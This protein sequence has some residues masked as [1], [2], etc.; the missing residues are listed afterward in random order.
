VGR[1]ALQV[2][3]A[4][5]GRF[6]VDLL[7]AHNRA[8][9][10]VEQARAFRP[11]AVV[12][13]N[14]AHYTAVR[15]ALAPLGIAVHA[16]DAAGLL[17]ER[18]PDLLLAAMVGFA[19]LAPTLAAAEAGIPL[20]LANKE[21]LVVAGE[22]I[23][24]A[25]ARHGLPVLPVDSEHSAIFQCLQGEDAHAVEKIIL[26]ASGGPFRGL[27]KASLEKV[28][29][30]EALKHPNWSMGP[31]ITVDSATLM[32][33]AL[34]MIEARWL[35]GL[36]PAQIEVV[37]H[38][39]SVIHSMVQFVDGSVKAQMG[40]PD[41]KLPIQYALAYPERWPSDFGGFSID[42]Y[43]ALTFEQPDAGAFPALTLAR[44]AMERGGNGPCVLNAANEAAVGAFLQGRIAFPRIA[45]TAAR[46]L[47]T[48]P[49]IEKP[50]LADYAETHEA[51]LA[52]AA[53]LWS[54]QK[55]DKFAKG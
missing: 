48:M 29:A 13:G 8:A 39:Q 14:G 7:T 54:P 15:D 49:F 22:L 42:A 34:E 32:N 20:A 17:R 11:G 30:E 21:T 1:Q 6:A 31:K 9:L 40:R 55:I 50:T 53:R 25:A 16:G 2:I 23:M 41:M 52:A 43:P 37:V 36:R 12:I 38:P 3:A 24:Q 47:E 33:K 51:T 27:S 35:F 45:E 46:C 26:T 18:K 28:T 10:L 19:G 44:E 5:A 4:H